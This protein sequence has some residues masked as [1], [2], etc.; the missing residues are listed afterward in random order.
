M[1]YIMTCNANR[2]TCLYYNH[3]HQHC[4]CKHLCYSLDGSFAFY[5]SYKAVHAV[6]RSFRQVKKSSRQA[7]ITPLSG[8]TLQAGRQSEMLAARGFR[9]QSHR[10][11]GPLRLRP[12]LPTTLQGK[13]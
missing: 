5:Y 3:D 2:N 13:R 4:T 7:K 1:T 10:S 11:I 9:L 8:K 6:A 12:T